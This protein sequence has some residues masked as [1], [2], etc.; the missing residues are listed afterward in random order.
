MNIKDNYI[1]KAQIVEVH[2]GD[3]IKLHVDDGYDVIRP[4]TIRFSVINTAEL[5]SH[6]QHLKMLAD[7]GRDYVKQFLG[8]EIYVESYR[9]KEGGFG[10]YLGIIYYNNGTEWINLNKELLDKGLAHVYE[11]GKSFAEEK[12]TYEGEWK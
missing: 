1:R 10:R 6:D 9:F 12:T 11:V 3:T 5:T 2:D 4:V 8:Q 7:E